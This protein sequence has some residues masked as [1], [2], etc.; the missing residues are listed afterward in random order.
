MVEV[1]AFIFRYQKPCWK[2]DNQTPVLYAFRPP[3]NE[4]H[5]ECNPE[6]FGMN[7]ITPDHDKRWARHYHTDSI[8]T[9]RDGPRLWKNK[10]MQVGAH[11]AESCKEIGLYGR[12]CLRCDTT[13]RSPTNSLIMSH[14]TMLIPIDSPL[15]RTDSEG[16][17]CLLYTSP[18]P[19]DQRGSR[20]PSSA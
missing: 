20:M 10:S 12:I 17:V 7:E 2:C 8:G 19:R 13:I 3:A 16:S 18:S 15:I 4:K 6:W 1:R 9:V 11:H 5:L 14:R